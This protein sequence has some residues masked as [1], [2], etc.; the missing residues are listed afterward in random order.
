MRSFAGKEN[1]AECTLL[2]NENLFKITLRCL[3]P[4]RY[5][6]ERVRK[7]QRTV[8]LKKSILRYMVPQPGNYTYNFA[9]LR[10]NMI[11]MRPPA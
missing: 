5:T 2:Q 4:N 9:N 3:A 10:R 1:L 6:V 7:Y 8:N 11:N